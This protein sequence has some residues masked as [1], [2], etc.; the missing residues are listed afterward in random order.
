MRKVL[1]Q[2][3]GLMRPTAADSQTN[4]KANPQTCFGSKENFDDKL[5]SRLFSERTICYDSSP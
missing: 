3:D 1:N 4:H 2:L 5:F